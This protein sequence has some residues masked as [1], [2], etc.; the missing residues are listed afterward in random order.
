MRDPR[1]VCVLDAEHTAERE[2]AK[3]ALG[4]TRTGENCGHRALKTR[5][6]PSVGNMPAYMYNVSMSRIKPLVR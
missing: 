1:E 3:S 2:R 5:P 4:V 6:L